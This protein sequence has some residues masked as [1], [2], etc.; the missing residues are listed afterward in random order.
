ML[1]LKYAT[2]KNAAGR[3]TTLRHFYGLAH[4][5][6]MG[7]VMLALHHNHRFRVDELVHTKAAV[8]TAI[9]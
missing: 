9:A 3:E 5:E 7:L 8:L 1:L 4:R 6:P 2:H